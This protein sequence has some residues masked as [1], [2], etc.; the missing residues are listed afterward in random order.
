MWP[1]NAGATTDKGYTCPIRN[2]Q[3][4]QSQI[5]SASFLLSPA[6]PSALTMTT[7]TA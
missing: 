2:N 5:Q 4:G 7:R 1:G 6:G 3:H